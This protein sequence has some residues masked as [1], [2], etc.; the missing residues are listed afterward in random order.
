[1]STFK[2]HSKNQPTLICQQQTIKIVKY[3]KLKR[4]LIKKKNVCK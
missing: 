2:N 3:Q 4:W 1:M